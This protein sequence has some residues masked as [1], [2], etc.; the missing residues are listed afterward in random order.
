MKKLSRTLLL[1]LLG[2]LALISTSLAR[3]NESLLKI[4]PTRCIALHEG[5][6][7]YQKLNISWQADLA[8]SYCLYQ[9]NN[10]T[11]L[12]CWENVAVGKWSYEFEG[13]TT[14]KFMLLRK[15]DAKQIAEVSIEVAWV[16]DASSKRESH[17]R[18]F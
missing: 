16:Y 3:A 1:T 10:K 14:Q 17:W 6:V 7:C 4:K 11:P 9:Q 2:A 12:M 13:A 8:D 5:Q 15:Q 18:V